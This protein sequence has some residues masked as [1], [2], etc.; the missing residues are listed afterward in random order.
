MEIKQVIVHELIKEA[1]K[2][3]DFSKPYQLRST[4]LDKT[5][6]IVIKLIQDISSLYGTKG[7]SAHYGV[8]KEEKT[9][10]GPVPSIFEE[11]SQSE[12]NINEKFVPFS[13]E[14]MK[15]LVKKAKEQPWSSGGFIVFCDYI[16]N[17]NKF[18]L[19]AMIKK[20]NGVT[21]SNKLEPEEMIHLDL[22]KIHQ[23]ARINF[24][25]YQQYKTADESEKIDLSYLSFVSKGVGQSTSAYFI[26]AIGCD[27][28]L[29]AA[30]ATKKLPTVAK[31]FFNQKP[32]LKACANRFKYDVI[33]YLDT[34]ATKNLSARLSDI[35]VIAARHMTN[36]D[37][38]TKESYTHELILFLNSENVRIPTEFVISK[39][40]LKDIKNITFKTDEI[41]FNFDKSL[42]GVTADD[43]VWYDET[44]GR[45]SFTNLPA[46]FKAKL[47]A[48]VKE[49]LKLRDSGKENG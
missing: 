38:S 47:S 13:I 23:A 49:N 46:E 1:K 14:V 31:Q 2:D 22:S 21:I 39:R 5:N 28:S 7:N 9:E 10:Q 36:L 40:A 12:D 15:Q 33:A 3:F 30:K 11:Y 48:V 35:E 29:A 18:F 24:N 41:G 25:L 26:A 16:V 42:L 17:N 6:P 8:F 43:D 32:E 4:P 34:Q 20:K 44:T 37:E 19:I 27:K 45:L